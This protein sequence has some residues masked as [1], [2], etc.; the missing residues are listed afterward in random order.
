MG[1]MD[2]VADQ[3]AWLRPMM[4]VHL[5]ALSTAL[6]GFIFP[7]A[8]IAAAVLACMATVAMTVAA[9]KEA[10]AGYAL[11]HLLLLVLLTPVFFIGVIGV[12]FLVWSDLT[13][14]RITIAKQDVEAEA[15]TP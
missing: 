9:T 12:P 8:L 4:T 11:P 5:A 7:D 6:V 3:I 14:R 2:Q 1:D 13:K 15:Q 10:G